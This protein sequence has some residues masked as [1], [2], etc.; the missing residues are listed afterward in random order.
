MSSSTNRN[1]AIKTRVICVCRRA[2][3]VFKLF[4][5]VGG[6][7]LLITL[8]VFVGGA[9]VLFTLFVFVG[10]AL[11]LFTLF[12]FVGNNVYKT[13]APPTNTYNINKIRVPLQTQI[14]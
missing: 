7:L 9:L 14:T 12:V 13:R 8:F 6:A 2:R 5:F 1:N 11:V 4:V 3:V 10:G